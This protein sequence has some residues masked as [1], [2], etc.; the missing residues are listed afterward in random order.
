MFKLMKKSSKAPGFT[1]H[2]LLDLLRLAGVRWNNFLIP[3]LFSIL[4][5]LAEGLNLLLLFPLCRGL[6]TGNYS[7]FKTEAWFQKIGLWAPVANWSSAQIFASL[8]LIIFL[9]AVTKSAFEYLSVLTVSRQI[10]QFSN[11]LRKIIFARFIFFGK[12]YFDINSFG[13]V[14]QNLLGSTSRIG[15]DL[16]SYQQAFTWMIQLVIYLAA[17][18]LISWQLTLTAFLIFPLFH[19]SSNWIIGKIK[20]TSSDYADAA[21]TLSKKVFNTFSSI[22]LVKS[23]RAENTEKSFFNSS[24]DTVSHYEYSLD[25][26][27][28]LIY[29]LQEVIF[30]V[31]M[32]SMVSVIALLARAK[33]A[34]DFS[35][36]L[37][38]FYIL[39]RSSNHF[40]SLTHVHASYAASSGIWKNL[41]ALMGDDE[42]Y[43]VVGGSKIFTGLE[44][45]ILIK[46]LSF[47][48]PSRPAVLKNCSFEIQ[49]GKMTA[50]VGATGAGKSTTVNLLCRFYQAPRASIYLDEVDINEF[51]LDSFYSRMAYV[52]QDVQLM[53]DSL[54]ANLL[55][56][57]DAS[58]ISQERISEVLKSARLDRYV[59]GLENGLETAVG[60]RGVQL[61]G[62]EKQRLSIARAILKNAAILILDEATSALD[63]QTEKLVQES[64]DEASRGR[65]TI[66]IAHR[67]STIKHADKVI[68]FEHGQAVESG[69]LQ[70]LLA[71]K[72]RFFELWEAQRFG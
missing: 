30:L 52:S 47:G 65:T 6:V 1:S 40:R 20:K 17:M 58:A 43:F 5:G 4:S 55:Y 7:F 24:S 69:T 49:K 38:F 27:E 18:F 8:V 26:K 39:R 61:S 72:D 3:S 29:P 21:N 45:S 37:V 42:K 25:K 9:S 14:Q 31:V 35:G 16:K 36:F 50:L 57:L 2:G 23:F 46:N 33:N 63:S 67:L 44:K 68:V 56:G 48:Y 11:N 60:D 59:A 32:L 13:V 22:V 66:V 41:I 34:P 51:S 71:K 64:I 10:R 70:E 62:G 19:Y 12:L 28:N 53:N 54:R 15:Y